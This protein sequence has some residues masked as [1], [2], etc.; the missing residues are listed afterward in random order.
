VPQISQGGPCVEN[1]TAW[2]ATA[3][4]HVLMHPSTRCAGWHF[5][6][7]ATTL[8]PKEAGLTG[9]AISNHGLEA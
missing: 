1:S 7:G 5:S 2:D 4:L 9:D 3:S 6:D 8:S